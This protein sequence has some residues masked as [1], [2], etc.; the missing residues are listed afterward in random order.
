M[1]HVR[2]YLFTNGKLDYY[3]ILCFW[4]IAENVF[5]QLET[6]FTRVTYST[7]I[8]GKFTRNI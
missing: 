1:F 3:F 6:S 2:F 8:T 4:L 7:I 5:V